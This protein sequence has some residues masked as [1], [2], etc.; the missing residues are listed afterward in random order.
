MPHR[1]VIVI[2]ALL[3]CAASGAASDHDGS[4][5]GGGVAG[6]V[7]RH[8]FPLSA[9]VELRLMQDD[10][11]RPPK[12]AG[13]PLAIVETDDQ[14]AFRFD[15]LDPGR[16]ELRA[17]G[18][19]MSDIRWFD[20]EIS[21]QRR[22]VRLSPEAV[23]PV[24]A[25]CAVWVDGS[26]FR[27]SVSSECGIVPTGEDGSFESTV[28]DQ[29]ER[30]IEVWQK[31]RIRRSMIIPPD[32]KVVIDAGLMTITGRVLSTE[33]GEALAGAIVS[34][35]GYLKDLGRVATV[36][37]TDVKGRYSLPV[38][39]E[40]P[41]TIRAAGF[42]P[43][44]LSGEELREVGLERAPVIRGRVLSVSDRNPIPGVPVF[45][46]GLV[47][48]HVEPGRF[49]LTR[50][51]RSFSDSRGRFHLESPVTGNVM[52]FV[53]G[54]GFITPGL[55]VATSAGYNPAA[56]HLVPGEDRSLDV[57]AM[58]SPSLTGRLTGPDG[59]GVPGAVV[60]ADSRPGG[61]YDSLPW[62]KGWFRTLTRS[63]TGADGSYR[64]PTLIPDV[65]WQIDVQSEG[66]SRPRSRTL[67]PSGSEEVRVDLRLPTNLPDR[68]IEVRAVSAKD[69]RPVPGTW[70]RMEPVESLVS[71]FA[72][73]R[74]GPDGRARLGPFSR[75]P[76]VAEATH[77][78]FS[79]GK[80]LPVPGSEGERRDLRMKI[81]LERGR[82]LAGVIRL[83]DGTAA[84]NARFSVSRPGAFARSVLH[85]TD[86]DGSFRVE[87]LAEGE[88]EIDLS[89]FVMQGIRWRGEKTVKADDED[90][91][92]TLRTD[93]SHT[94]T[95][96]PT[97]RVPS[98]DPEAPGVDILVRTADGKPV[99][100]GVIIVRTLYQGNVVDDRITGRKY[101][102]FT[103]GK[104]RFT[105]ERNET[106]VWLDI[107][108]GGK[109][110]PR[111]VGPFSAT[112]S[113][114][115]IVVRPAGKIVGRVI[116]PAEGGVR[117]A[118]VLAV[119]ANRGL[120]E[121]DETAHRHAVALCDEAGRFRL[122]GLG[123]DE[124]HLRVLG[125]PTLMEL[126]LFSARA[127]Q[128]S[129]VIRLAA[130]VAPTIVVT[131]S[132]D[133]PVVDARARVY[134]EGDDR[135][136]RKRNPIRSA[137]TDM[138]GV[139]RLGHLDPDRRYALVIDLSSGRRSLKPIEVH[140]WKPTDGTFRFVST[141]TVTGI[142]R[143]RDG[144]PISRAI[145]W[146]LLPGK[147]GKWERTRAKEDGRYTIRRLPHRAIHLVAHPPWRRSRVPGDKVF[148]L[149]SDEGEKDLMI[150][151]GPVLS[152]RVKDWPDG[153]TAQ[154]CL[155][156]KKGRSSSMWS[157][158]M[159]SDGRLRLH[160]YKP[161]G[162]LVFWLGLPDGR[163]ALACLQPDVENVL[164]LTPGKSIEGTLE[165]P[166]GA[167]AV[168]LTAWCTLLG[169]LLHIEVA[170][171]PGGRFRLPGLPDGTY[172]LLAT[173]KVG[174]VTYESDVKVEA[175]SSVKVEMKPR[176]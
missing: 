75:R 21:G 37:I 59:H 105:F 142:V 76:L 170:V 58:R 107:R 9:R 67:R 81:E 88:W 48:S 96:G 143:D 130:A 128:E 3:L 163:M 150:D 147:K 16:Y 23:G 175:G 69:G 168:K 45:V 17:T 169:H 82:I 49:A 90:I 71:E 38:L 161:G 63:V 134:S 56:L 138:T 136:F 53:F 121:W 173:A 95:S 89:S 46:L 104:A 39:P 158:P 112:D 61:D 84:S 1:A 18:K 162:K 72:R 123:G 62:R 40:E 15:R 27:G 5:R 93:R 131:D 79:P 152:V 100:A 139:A 118:R 70:V 57:P 55:D 52:V 91:V 65:S 115:E 34:F 132:D 124:Y 41:V 165:L 129:V 51:A 157:R 73:E 110:G 119:P 114:V 87:G 43:R 60:K 13:A 92:L 120:E 101:M 2:V 50:V 6:F 141:R 154:A 8:G 174:T 44:R 4:D 30:R 29:S 20:I 108:P 14:G 68:W 25:G 11:V 153:A 42:L 122:D 22:I 149:S 117:G 106:R 135:P 172:Q 145:V 12:A 77:R 125:P 35:G 54:R 32:G 164:P 7:T 86:A 66:R 151:G 98:V 83:P 116:G 26:P 167:R 111:L 155:G 159:S 102:R 146:Y 140:D 74:T 127:E 113:P 10:F 24:I 94:I 103:D 148:E 109:L 19:G 78:A 85:R 171:E 28:G 97:R 166:K 160:C 80:D 47:D 156:W 137:T 144:F 99:A 31:G 36:S 126:D 33:T 133:R 64:I 176:K